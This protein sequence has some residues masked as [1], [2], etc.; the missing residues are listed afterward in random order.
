[1]FSTSTSPSRPANRAANAFRFRAVSVRRRAARSRMPR[2]HLP[3]ELRR[4]RAA[5]DRVR[6]HVRVRDRARVDERERPLERGVVL[7]GKAAI[8]SVPIDA[9][10]RYSRIIASRSA[11]S[12]VS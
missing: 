1:V 5:S 4:R 9:S 2:R 12:A 7:A 11:A 6:E 8:R 10:G 3:V